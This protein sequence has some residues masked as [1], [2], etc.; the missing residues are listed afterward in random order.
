MRKPNGYWTKEKC[1]EEIEKYTNRSEFQKKSKGAYKA[2][3]KNKWIDELFKTEPKHKPN[4]YWT[5]QRCK[6]E[7]AKYEI[8]AFDENVYKKMLNKINF[9]NYYYE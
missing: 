2:C 5:E 9:K 8:Y 7:V 3:F 1:K 4:G 6:E